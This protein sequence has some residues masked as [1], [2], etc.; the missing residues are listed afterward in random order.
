MK[1]NLLEKI[2]QSQEMK[3]V[4]E[5]ENS[6][7]LPVNQDSNVYPII[8]SNN[9]FIEVQF[10]LVITLVVL[11]FT[12]IAI[13]MAIFFYKYL[14]DKYKCR[15]YRWRNNVTSLLPIRQAANNLNS[16]TRP[17]V[18]APFLPSGSPP[19]LPNNKRHQQSIEVRGNTDNVS[20]IF[21]SET[22]A[23]S[24]KHL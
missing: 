18:S 16:S 9:T 17:Q 12:I 22:Q 24:F 21:V 2:R 14:P 6:Y 5:Y 4:K 13:L 8:N 15:Q 7:P 11:S 1:S 20:V 3:N 10:N 19:S 23:S